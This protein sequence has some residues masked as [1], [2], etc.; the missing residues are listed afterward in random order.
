L[1]TCWTPRAPK[2]TLAALG[3]EDRLAG[4][5]SATSPQ[6]ARQRLAGDAPDRHDPLAGALAHDLD[7][8]VGAQVGGAQAGQLR[9]AQ[10]GVEEQQHDGAVA[11]RGTVQQ[12]A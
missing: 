5:G 8:A 7:T 12:L 4:V 9:Q 3:A 6:V 2:R 1:K 10:A 11:D